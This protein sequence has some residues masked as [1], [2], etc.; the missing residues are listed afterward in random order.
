[1]MESQYRSRLCVIPTDLQD[2]LKM[3]KIMFL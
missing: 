1:M 3:L 2:A